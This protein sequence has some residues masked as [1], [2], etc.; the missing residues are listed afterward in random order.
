MRIIEQ[1]RSVFLFAIIAGLSNPAFAQAQRSGVAT[2][3]VV[4]NSIFILYHEIG[5]LL[6]S[7]LDIPILGR[8][9]KIGRA[10]V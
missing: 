5:H 1:F 7:E 2:E 3:F 6:I 9:E 4:S 8:E 10:H